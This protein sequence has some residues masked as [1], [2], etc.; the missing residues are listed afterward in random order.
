M[1][2]SVKRKAERSEIAVSKLTDAVNYEAGSIASKTI[3]DRK[4][5]S[6]AVF[7]YDKFQQ[8]VEHVLPYD[9]IFLVL[10]GEAEVIISGKVHTVKT[11]EIIA[12]PANKPHSISAKSKFKM[13]LI[14]IKE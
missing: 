6:V 11:G 2:S 10:E 9:V 1:A 12:F 7:A 14:T 8:I 3:I 4:A 5:A 13:M